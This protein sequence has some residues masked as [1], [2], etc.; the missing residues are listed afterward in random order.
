MAKRLGLSLSPAFP[1]FTDFRFEWRRHEPSLGFY[2]TS[3]L[4]P[5]PE[6]VVQ[7]IEWDEIYGVPGDESSCVMTD[8]CGRISLD[9][10]LRIPG[11]ENGR[12]VGQQEY[13]PPN[14]A[15]RT[16]LTMRSSC[17]F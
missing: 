16:C 6:G 10:A 12:L 3:K 11:I 2:S 9:L 1:L 5:P 13:V 7:F 4:Q 14:V 15:S 17:P 8:G